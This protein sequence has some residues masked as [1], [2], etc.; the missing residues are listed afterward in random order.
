MFKAVLLGSALSVMFASAALAT[1]ST[2]ADVQAAVTPVFS[3]L[4]AFAIAL[5]PFALGVVI[6]GI[7]FRLAMGWLRKARA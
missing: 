1:P 4:K 2:T 5:I 6:V 3:D 7:G